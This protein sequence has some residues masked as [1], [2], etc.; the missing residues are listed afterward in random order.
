MAF[1]STSSGP[2]T[3]GFNDAVSVELPFANKTSFV[4]ISVFYLVMGLALAFQIGWSR[5]II[6]GPIYIILAAVTLWRALAHRR[7]SVSPQELIYEVTALGLNTTRR[8]ALEEIKN[9]RVGERRIF[10][11]RPWLA[12]DRKGRRKFIGEQLPATFPLG[13]LDPI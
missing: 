6:I 13:L 12:V 9:L 4:L 8:Y 10:T 1:T 2:S 5:D 11:Y 7:I 3:T